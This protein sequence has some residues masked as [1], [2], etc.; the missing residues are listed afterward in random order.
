MRCDGTGLKA[1]GMDRKWNGM[2]WDGVGWNG[3]EWDGRNTHDHLPP[4][5]ITHSSTP[6]PPQVRTLFHMFDK[7]GKGH[8]D[9][10]EWDRMIDTFG[11]PVR[12][13]SVEYSKG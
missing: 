12:T 2:G 4:R 7:D 9:F 11:L 1:N 5:D 6:D 3:M 13:R 10:I 8:L